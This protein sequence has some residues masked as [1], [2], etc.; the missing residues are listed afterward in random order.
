MVVANDLRNELRPDE[1]NG[2]MPTW[3][4]GVESNDWRMA[5]ERAGN[6]VL[7]YNSNSLVIV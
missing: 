6:E 1:N 4:S 3:G 2:I 5:A 7:K